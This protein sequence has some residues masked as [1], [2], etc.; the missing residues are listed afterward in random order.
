MFMVGENWRKKRVIIGR[1]IQAF[2]KNFVNNF[3]LEYTKI[4]RGAANLRSVPGGRHPSYATGRTMYISFCS[5]IWHEF[6]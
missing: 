4:P 6:S 1:K 5:N 2:K 3:G